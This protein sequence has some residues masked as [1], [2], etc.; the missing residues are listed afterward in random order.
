MYWRFCS[1][2]YLLKGSFINDV[3]VVGLEIFCDGTSGERGARGVKKSFMDNLYML[4]ESY[5]LNT[6]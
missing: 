2:D 6:V 1:A 3:T 4:K 5:L